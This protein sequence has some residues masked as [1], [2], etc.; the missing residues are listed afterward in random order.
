MRLFRK[1]TG[2]GCEC[3]YLPSPLLIQRRGNKEVALSGR[4]AGLA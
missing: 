1:A 2:R 3:L 4:Q